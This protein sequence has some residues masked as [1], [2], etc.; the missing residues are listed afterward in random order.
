MSR[1]FFR[2]RLTLEE[3]DEIRNQRSKGIR[4]MLGV[5]GIIFLVAIAVFV[6]ATVL[7]PYMELYTLRQEQEHVEAQ[8]HRAQE[9]EE[10]A[11][12]IYNWMSDFEFFEQIARDSAH[13]AKDGEK[14]IHIP[15][16]EPDTPATGK[17]RN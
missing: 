4:E 9:A 5:V 7:I 15:A 11:H 14:V 13:K 12:N 10:E 1:S 3:Q 8:L 2:R 6:S 17:A 16:A